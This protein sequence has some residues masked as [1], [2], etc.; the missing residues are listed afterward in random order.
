M[1]HGPFRVGGGFGDRRVLRR[2]R[3]LEAIGGGG[4][5]VLCGLEASLICLCLGVGLSRILG[6]RKFCGDLRLRYEM[7]VLRLVF[8]FVL[9]V[10]LLGLFL[11]WLCRCLLLVM[12]SWLSVI[13]VES[14]VFGSDLNE[15]DL[16]FGRGGRGSTCLLR[17]V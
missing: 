3:G 2:D 10:G 15:E 4:G 13:S 12:L 17:Q 8:V 1:A 16:L 9:N 5:L 11:R 14:R 7:R 6:R